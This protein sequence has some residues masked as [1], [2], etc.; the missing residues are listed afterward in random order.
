MIHWTS[1]FGAAWFAATAG[2]LGGM[3]L[4]SWFQQKERE[5]I[6]GKS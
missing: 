6:N 3:A 2:I 4:E 1:L 5:R